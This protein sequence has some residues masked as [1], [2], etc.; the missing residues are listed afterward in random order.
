[1]GSPRQTEVCRT[2]T[3]Q[4]QDLALTGKPIRTSGITILRFANGKVV[5][6]CARW[7]TLGLMQQ[8]G[9]IPK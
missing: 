4:L 1:L 8:L 3:N 2:F 9:A 5:E 6:E 7:D